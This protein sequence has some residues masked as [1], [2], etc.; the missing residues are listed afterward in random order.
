MTNAEERKSLPFLHQ[1]M[2]KRG[3]YE[4]S[5]CAFDVNKRAID[6][7]IAESKHQTMLDEFL[8]NCLSGVKS[9]E[10]NSIK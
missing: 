1:F 3:S 2:T 8:N 5:L 7:C 6:L 4:K 10:I 9:S